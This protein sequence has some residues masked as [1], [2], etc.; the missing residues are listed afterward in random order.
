MRTSAAATQQLASAVTGL[1]D[2]NQQIHTTLS[3][4]LPDIAQAFANPP[5]A[6][7][8]GLNARLGG[9]QQSITSYGATSNRP[10]APTYSPSRPHKWANDMLAM[11]ELWNPALH[12][13]LTQE[14]RTIAA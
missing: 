4:V 9:L 14:T 13:L 1:A 12:D 2:L 6:N 5:A 7:V 3:T 11:T 8:F 10:L